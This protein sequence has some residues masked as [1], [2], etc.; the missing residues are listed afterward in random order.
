ARREN[1]EIAK[2][3]TLGRSC[4][5]RRARLR[6]PQSAP[7]LSRARAPASPQVAPFLPRP[8][9]YCP[10]ARHPPLARAGRLFAR[11][12]AGRARALLPGLAR[13]S[14]RRLFPGALSNAAPRALLAQPPEKSSIPHEEKRRF[15]CR[16]LP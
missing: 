11:G 1:E 2:D 13:A 6:G 10:P 9:R 12:R 8:S 15:R 7:F 4:D 3:R 5:V 16:A 14:S